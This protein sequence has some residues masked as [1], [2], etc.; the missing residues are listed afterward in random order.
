MKA[1]VTNLNQ[2]KTTKAKRKR[3]AV[4]QSPAREAIKDLWR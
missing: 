2:F 1:S 4:T 3:D